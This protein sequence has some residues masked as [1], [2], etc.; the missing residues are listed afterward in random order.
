M[1]CVV[2]EL[3][4]VLLLCGMISFSGG[5][6]SVEVSERRHSDA[7]PFFPLSGEMSQK[8]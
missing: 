3:S 2:M 5:M 6:Q 4:V 8:R 7:R 1:V